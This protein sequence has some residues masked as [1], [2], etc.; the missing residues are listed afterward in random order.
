MY[1]LIIWQLLTSQSYVAMLYNWLII[2]Q[3]IAVHDAYT[4]LRHIATPYV[5]DVVLNS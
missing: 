1:S 5:H 4:Q 2:S 3:A